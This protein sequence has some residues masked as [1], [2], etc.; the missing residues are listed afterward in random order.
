MIGLDTNV[1][2]RFFTQDDTQQSEQATKLIDQCSADNPGYINLI[3][4]AELFWLL[5]CSYQYSRD[6]QITLLRHMLQLQ[7][8]V[9][10]A[11]GD[12]YCAITQFE[13][14]KAP[15]AGCL[16]E[17]RNQ[18]AGCIAAFTFDKSAGKLSGFSLIRC[19]A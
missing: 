4:L 14:G 10:E 11:S 16:I 19:S 2:A 8:L 3:V 12:V 17:L 9:I 15:L 5:D 18:S 7:N 1:L 6:Q 13:A